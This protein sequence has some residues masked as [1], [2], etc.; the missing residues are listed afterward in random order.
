MR[1]LAIEYIRD[2]GSYVRMVWHVLRDLFSA[3]LPWAPTRQQIIKL[4]LNSLPIILLTAI[5]TGMVLALQTAYG[6]Q[7]F[8]A[9]T[10][11]GNITSLAMIRELGPVLTALMLCGRVGAGIAAEIASMVATEQVDAIRVLG[12]NPIRKLVT[13][14][15]IAVVLVMPV[16]CIIANVIGIYG[17]GLMAVLELNLS[18]HTYY[19]SILQ[20]ILIRD[21][22]DGLIKSTIFGFLVVSIACWKGLHTRGGTVGVGNTTTSAVV[23]GS[24]VILISDFFI[25]KFLL[26]L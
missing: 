2:L 23:T 9:K 25:T 4:G 7:R 16:L 13:P 5:F 19:K 22:I 10:Y 11:V 18:A 8:G 6:M 12:A 14:R 15:V 21:L 3:R 26:L 24:V 20:T 17:G 1:E